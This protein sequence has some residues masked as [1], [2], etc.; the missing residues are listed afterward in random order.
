MSIGMRIRYFRRKRRMT[1]KE[2]GM[3]VGFSERTA[4]IR[5]AQYESDS[6]T[7]K[8]ELLDAFA[9][10]LDVS[11]RALHVPDIDSIY[12]VLHTFFVIEDFY[13]LTIE[14]DS[15]KGVM[16]VDPESS[17]SAF[18]L[19]GLIDSWAKEAEKFKAG[20][21]TKEEYDQWRYNYPVSD[22]EDDDQP[23]FSAKECDAM[24]RKALKEQGLL[25]KHGELDMRGLP[26]YQYQRKKR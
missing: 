25:D 26:G 6:R 10:A 1:Q 15:G 3:K 9:R 13:G 23:I 24:I 4:D 5:V 19:S 20:E 22:G 12:G 21:I 16:R 7:P 14:Y 17:V 8:Q 11:P 18:G 2:I